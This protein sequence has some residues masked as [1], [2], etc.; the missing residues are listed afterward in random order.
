[1]T[2]ANAMQ[3]TISRSR[4]RPSGMVCRIACGAERRA[5]ADA[6]GLFGLGHVLGVVTPADLLRRLVRH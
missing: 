4:N 3:T 1:M 2:S 6:G 5:L